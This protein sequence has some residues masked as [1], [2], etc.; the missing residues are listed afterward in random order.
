MAQVSVTINGRQYRI[1]CEDGQETHLRRLAEGFDDRISQFR[2]KFGEIGDA[3]LTVMASIAIADEL[4][5]MAQR[6]RR[7]EEEIAALEN[8]RTAAADRAQATQAAI[9][10]AFNAAAERIEKVTR[11]LNMQRG[12][13]PLS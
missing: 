10:A 13:L 8:V 3:R 11:G 5:E 9:V 1:A 6:V 12:T 2:G 4:S 7:L